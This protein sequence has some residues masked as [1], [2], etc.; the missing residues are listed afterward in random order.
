MTSN[1]C[2]T[3]HRQSSQDA[4]AITL[5]DFIHYQMCTKQHCYSRKLFVLRDDRFNKRKRLTVGKWTE[6]WNYFTD[7]DQLDTE[8]K[9]ANLIT[10]MF[11]IIVFF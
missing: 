8:D 6:Q 9:P 4:H 1:S 10:F 11:N 2:E 3:N 5:V 7:F